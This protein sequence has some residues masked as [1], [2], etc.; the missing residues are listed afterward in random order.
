MCLP[1]LIDMFDGYSVMTVVV[2][3]SDYSHGHGLTMNG[4][5]ISDVLDKA[6]WLQSSQNIP[7]CYVTCHV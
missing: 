6:K 2:A 1:R 3:H 5:C 4:K 7:T